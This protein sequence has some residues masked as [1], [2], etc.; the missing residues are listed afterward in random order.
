MQLM[1]ARASCVN[2]GLYSLEI[3]LQNFV[4]TYTENSLFLISFFKKE[5][6]RKESETYF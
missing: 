6:K 4:Y 5:K 3:L 2:I 1:A